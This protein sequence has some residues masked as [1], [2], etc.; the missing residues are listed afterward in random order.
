M[1]SSS[2]ETA[3]LSA[4]HS[5]PD[6]PDIFAI[7][8]PKPETPLPEK[9]VRTKLKSPIYNVMSTHT[10]TDTTLNAIDKILDSERQHNKTETWNK[11]DKTVKMEKLQHFAEKYGREQALPVKEIKALKAFFI[12][13]LD[14]GKLQKTKD[15]VYN[16]DDRE[17][18]SIPCLHFNVD[19]KCFTLRASSKRVSTLK[20]LT[21]KRA[22]E[23]E[24]LATLSDS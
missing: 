4:D 2:E 8:S 1:F 17:I 21:P 5:K 6:R 16:K 24:D 15:V 11:L 22:S 20:S 23:K 7:F 10:L 14:K 19:K 13:C 3:V 12:D 18:T 9:P